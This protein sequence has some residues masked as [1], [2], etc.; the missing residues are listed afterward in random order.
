MAKKRTG[1]MLV[2]GGDEDPDEDRMEILPRLVE[3]AGG[4]H[5]KIVV[6]SAPS[7]EPEEKVAAYAPLFRKLGAKRVLGAPISTREEAGA[8]AMLEAVEWASAVFFTGGDQLRL[9]AMLAG[10]QFC[11]R[12]RERLFGDGLIVAG[13]SAGAA[14]LSSVMII[15]GPDDA[16]VR[17]DEVDLAPGLGLWREVVIDTHFNQRGRVHR[18]L[19]TLASNPQ[20]LG[21]GIDENT[22]LDLVPG[23]RFKVLGDGAVMVFNGRVTHS[24]APDVSG[25][26]TLAITDVKLHVL[27]HG[28]GFNLKS[29]RPVVPGRGE[30]A[31]AMQ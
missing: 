14:A 3:M 5:A 1:R 16:T 25:D 20:V 30:L 19:T 26:E 29:K 2:I 31:D 9:T 10:T 28:Y 12:I 6:C 23:D 8:P 18:L 27:P 13:T 22:A 21:I 7:A 15:G 17:R 24:N 11:E 4:R